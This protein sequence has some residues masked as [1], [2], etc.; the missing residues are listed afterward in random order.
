VVGVA[1][2][3]AV[4]AVAVVVVVVAPA[5]TVV[6]VVA[7]AAGW[8]GGLFRYR[9]DHR[10]QLLRDLAE[11]QKRREEMHDKRSGSTGEWPLYPLLPP[12]LSFSSPP[13]PHTRT[14]TNTPRAYSRVSQTVPT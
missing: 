3:A 11:I 12:L 6:D 5:A 4:V 1:F 2:V 8:V 14:Y 7:A 10:E 9:A 13:P